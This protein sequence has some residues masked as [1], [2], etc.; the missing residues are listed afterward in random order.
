METTVQNIEKSTFGVYTIVK[1]FDKFT[2]LITK[3]SPRS[4]MGIK[5]VHHYG[6][7]SY[8]EV[9]ERIMRMNLFVEK[10]IEAQVKSETEK[11][12]KKLALQH[13][14]KQF[15]NPFEVGQILYN[16]WGYDQTNIDF[17]QVVAINGKKVTVQ[18][19]SKTRTYSGDDYG[20][21]MPDRDSFIG[22]LITKVIVIRIYND[23]VNAN[24]KNM[25][26]WDGSPKSWSS[27]H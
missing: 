15:K 10:F 16:S 25:M 12:A 24:I 13:A 17:Y 20:T 11:T 18:E 1:D 4:R 27:Y 5:Y 23:K 7:R 26:V 19:I 9:S 22:D 21:C 8:K 2:V 14:R 6:Y 3:P